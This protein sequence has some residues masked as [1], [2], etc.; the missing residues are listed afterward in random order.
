[1]KLFNYFRSGT[2]FRVRIALNLKGLGYDYLAVHLARGEHQSDSYRAL[3]PDGL[4][5]LLELDAPDQ[6]P[7]VRLSQSLAIIEYL[8]ECHPQ[9]PLLPADALGRAQV[10]ALALSIACEVHPINNLRVLKYLDSALGLSEAQRADWYNHWVSQGLLA[11]E[12]RLRLLDAERRASGLGKARFSYGD[13]P[14]LADCCLVPQMVNASRFG[15]SFEALDI[16]LTRAVFEAC[17]QIDAFE[18]ALPQNCPDA[19]A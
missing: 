11:Y 8:D 16:P 4:V 2:S 5:P 17:M 18:R 6:G 14:S 10:R 15:L 19:G 7:A 3:S 9:P 12:R 13:S 1:M